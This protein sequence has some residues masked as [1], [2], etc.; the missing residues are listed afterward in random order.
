M[1]YINGDHI[2]YESIDIP[3]MENIGIQSEI[4]CNIL[5]ASLLVIDNNVNEYNDNIYKNKVA[6]RSIAITAGLQEDIFDNDVYGIQEGGNIFIRIVKSIFSLLYK[7]MKFIF[8]I[9]DK[10][11][12]LI[13]GDKKDNIENY[14]K[15]VKECNKDILASSE[16]K[17]CYS[18]NDKEITLITMIYT[19]YPYFLI[20]GN[21]DKF[22]D[23]YLNDLDNTL[24]KT[25]YSIKTL[26]SLVN[27]IISGK[28][29][30]S[31]SKKYNSYN[32]IYEDL[33]DKKDKDS[34]YNTVD[35]N[36]LELLPK[37]VNEITDNIYD[38]GR[39]MLLYSRLVQDERYILS[40]AKIGND[41][42]LDSS[43][44]PEGITDKDWIE[45]ICGKD[46][47]TIDDDT[48]KFKHVKITNDII[49]KYALAS[50]KDIAVNVKKETMIKY[51]E[52]ILKIR[53]KYDV[54]K[55]LIDIAGMLKEFIKKTEKIETVD[56]EITGLDEK[57]ANE[58]RTKI[59]GNIVK[60]Y[61]S[62]VR[63]LSS[64]I[65]NVVVDQLYM[66]NILYVLM[67]R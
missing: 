4:L 54:D 17:G 56:I 30:I 33:K 60:L 36:F 27:A 63:P 67:K 62:Q 16:G 6:L 10:I 61:N 41:L 1:D 3:E 37:E 58:V 44:K 39:A 20:N 50:A 35:T 12:E 52:G 11:V 57:V 2:V 18:I 7:V 24:N 49:K 21:D 5:D 51:L 31:F 29:K 22:L 45:A 23:K 14:L 25:L 59:V 19:F 66:P 46:I 40:F 8:S 32:E 64:F 43:V 53:R 34:F 28:L 38:V 47:L 65:S 42:K 15:R 26:H 48:L 13:T 55:E 9:M